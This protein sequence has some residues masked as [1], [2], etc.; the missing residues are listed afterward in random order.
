MPGFAINEGMFQIPEG[1]ED[2]S[3]TA[4]SFPKGA[5]IPSA[6]LTVTRETLTDP[7]LALAP[8]VDA[9]LTKLAKTCHAF[10]ILHRD[11]W[12]ICGDPAQR[13]EF[14]WTTPERMHIHQLM[15]VMFWGAQALVITATATS[16]KF[17]EYHAVFEEFVANFRVRH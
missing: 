14:T 7:N 13:I 11:D 1:W 5:A 4:L 2:K 8:Y 9:Q 10:Q 6:S 16:D 15:T 12:E 17:P 3:I